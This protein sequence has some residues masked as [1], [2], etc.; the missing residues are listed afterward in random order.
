V[1][2]AIA[3]G[4]LGGAAGQAWDLWVSVL[5]RSSGVKDSG[6]IL[7][8]HGGILD[9]ADALAFTAPAT[10]AYGHFIAGF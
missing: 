1:P 6:G 2:D 4:I 3:L 5:K 7:P 10:W 9:R 8:G